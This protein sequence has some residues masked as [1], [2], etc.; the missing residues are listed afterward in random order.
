MIDVE[1]MDRLLRALPE[2]ARLVLLGD[3][4]QLPSV[5]AGHVLR[6]LAPPDETAPPALAGRVVRLT[7]SH[8]MRA[9]DPAGARILASAQAVRAG[10]PA[11]LLTSDASH[12]A[13]ILRRSRP[14]DLTFTAVEGLLSPLALE[15]LPALLERW[16]E[17]RVRTTGDWVH[18]L[19]RQYR[20][21]GGQVVGADDEAHLAQLFTQ[22]AGSRLLCPGRRGR[23]GRDAV[24][25]ALHAVHVR[26]LGQ[27]RVSDLAVGEPVLMTRNDYEREL[28]NGD[29]G[30][31]L[32]VAVDGQKARS[33][34]VFRGNDGRTRAFH[35]DLLRRDL[36]RSFATTVHK[37]QGGEHDVVGVVLPDWPTPLLVREVLYTALTRARRGVVVIGDPELLAAGVR[38]RIERASGIAELLRR[39][40]PAPQGGVQ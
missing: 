37:A 11:P 14:G 13:S 23:G 17:A 6:D 3:A 27:K 15:M 2:S 5:G 4:D 24:N 33:M 29:Q 8:R 9:D 36:E 7:Q 22:L 32:R 1:L 30:L 26:A 12:P 40:S 10:L 20:I 18:R 28:W 19:Q 16:H 38:E 39:D 31:I 34:A 21:E 25:E 35:L